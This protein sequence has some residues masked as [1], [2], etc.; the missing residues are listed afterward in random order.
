MSMHAMRMGIADTTSVVANDRCCGG[1]CRG[2]LV[3]APQLD[4]GGRHGFAA[5]SG[6]R[7]HSEA[8]GAPGSSGGGVDAREGKS[9][10]HGAR[11]GMRGKDV[12]S[13]GVNDPQLA[14]LLLEP[15]TT[16]KRGNNYI[17][18]YCSAVVSY[19]HTMG[20]IAMVIPCSG[21]SDF[22]GSRGAPV[23]VKAGVTAK[24]QT[25]WLAYRAD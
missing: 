22:D 20:M 10:A 15:S 16:E 17:N 9:R 14:P 4:P 24:W 25:T 6:G 3:G 18:V 19:V 13:M 12:R 21:H 5:A 1:R 11:P 7:E 2:M 23:H 8:M